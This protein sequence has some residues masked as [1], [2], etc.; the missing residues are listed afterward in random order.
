MESVKNEDLRNCV[1]DE[2]VGALRV[3]E[4]AKEEI[5]GLINFSSKELNIPKEELC[6]RVLVLVLEYF[7]K[8]KK[9][10]EK[11]LIFAI[12]IA[13]GKMKP[14]LEVPCKRTSKTCLAFPSLKIEDMELETLEYLEEER[15]HLRYSNLLAKYSSLLSKKERGILFSTFLYGKSTISSEDEV[16]EYT[17][18]VSRLKELISRENPEAAIEIGERLLIIPQKTL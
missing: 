18:V 7:E 9:Y 3:S 13:I 16:A 8:H 4:N 6:G 12:K 15:E 10:K 17:D 5:K 14:T 1:I 11:D 2:E